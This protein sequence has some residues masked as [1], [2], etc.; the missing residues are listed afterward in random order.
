MKLSILL[1][2]VPSRLKKFS[3]I[4]ELTKQAEGKQ[5]EIL[6]L[7]DNFKMK[8]G[9]KRNNLIYLATGKYICFVDDDDRVEPDYV[10]KILE[11]INTHDVDCINFQ[12]SVKINNG[13]AKLCYYSREYKKNE[14]LADRYLRQPNHLMVWRKSIIELF[15]E[16]NI[17]EDNQFGVSMA[18]KEYTEYCIDKVLYH[19]DFNSQTTEAQKR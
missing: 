12:A 4:E 17:G 5:V 8:V 14:N 19:Y 6:Y 18:S 13:P 3:I 15:P 9:E 2:S 1:C 11:A 16:I 10:H 7:G